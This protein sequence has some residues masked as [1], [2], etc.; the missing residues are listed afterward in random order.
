MATTWLAYYQISL[1]IDN[2][3]IIV[4][5]KHVCNAYLLRMRGEEDATT[6][7]LLLFQNLSKFKMC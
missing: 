5:E 1:F 7:M 4:I 2:E 3:T 6:R